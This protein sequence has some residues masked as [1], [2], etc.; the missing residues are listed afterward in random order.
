MTNETATTSA[1][2]EKTESIRNEVQQIFAKARKTRL[3]QDQWELFL[4]WGPTPEIESSRKP[5]NREQIKDFIEN[6][7]VEQQFEAI[8][9]EVEAK[10]AAALGDSLSETQLKALAQTDDLPAAAKK[11]FWELETAAATAL[12][13]QTNAAVSAARLWPTLEL[14]GLTNVKQKVDEKGQPVFKDGKPVGEDG[15]LMVD[16]EGNPL[17]YYE[18]ALADGTFF[19]KVTGLRQMVDTSG[20]K[21]EITATAAKEFGLWVEKTQTNYKTG[22]TAQ[23]EIESTNEQNLLMRNVL[24][25]AN[26]EGGGGSSY[27]NAV[28]R[29]TPKLSDGGRGGIGAMRALGLGGGGRRVASAAPAPGET[30]EPGR[31]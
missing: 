18:D 2:D 22:K 20:N 30:P 31:G 12:Q 29:S 8:A 17:R 28:Y 25:E 23:L 6:H 26:A 24:R 15:K 5:P 3:T 21:V 9:P 11:K 14:A 13:N 1:T 27:Y 16:A 10:I 4:L 7:Q 19:N